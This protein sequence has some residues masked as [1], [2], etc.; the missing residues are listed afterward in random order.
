MKSLQ[1]IFSFTIPFLFFVAQAYSKGTD[2][3]LENGQNLASDDL[4]QQGLHAFRNGFDD[5]ATKF[6]EKLVKEIPFSGNWK[7]KITVLSRL[8]SAYQNLGMKRL[9]LA[10]LQSALVIAN[11][12][13]SEF[14]IQR[15]KGQLGVS[16]TYTPDHKQAE[17]FLSESLNMAKAE[18]NK[19]TITLALMNMGNLRFVEERFDEAVD[20]FEQCIE[21]VDS[22]MNKNLLAKVF[23]NA[24]LSAERNNNWEDSIKFV[25]RGME[26]LKQSED[27]YEK[28]NLLTTA[29]RTYHTLLIHY[30]SLEQNLIT[31]TYNAY[32]SAIKVA[33]DLNNSKFLSYA[34]GYLSEL[35]EFKNLETEALHLARKAAFHAQTVNLPEAL[36]QWQWQV[37]DLLKKSGRL[38]EAIRAYT[39]AVET[40]ETIRHDLSN[41]LGNRSD[42]SSFFR[43]SNALYFE[44]ADLLLL[45]AE[46]IESS[47]KSSQYL[48][49]AREVIELLKSAEIEDYLRD[50]CANIGSSRLKKI[51]TVAEDTA[52][53]YIIPLVDRVELLV[54]ISE[55][56][57]GFKVAITKTILFSEVKRFRNQLE[58]RPIH[59]YLNSAQRIYS[60]LIEPLYDLMVSKGITTLVFISDGPLRTVPMAAL[61]DGKEFLIN[62][63]AIA[64]SPGLTLMAPESIVRKELQVIKSG[65]SESVQG[66]PP[67]NYVTS[68]LESIHELLGGELLL[69]HDFLL[70]DMER[71]VMENQYTIVHIASHGRFHSDPKQ[72]FVLTYDDRLTLNRLEKI[73]RTGQF[74]GKPIELLTLS[75]CETAAGDDRAALGLAGVAMKSGARSVLATLWNINDQASSN[76]IIEFYEQLKIHPSMSKA[77]AL[78]QAQ[79]S[80]LKDLRYDHPC[81]WSPFLI[82]GNWL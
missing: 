1:F 82:V 49:R 63:F 67:L 64:V 76:L 50:E 38:E 34:Y 28:A 20:Y 8:A 52:I 21:L 22:Q 60:W 71:E 43:S 81:Y 17:G 33:E 42:H 55:E 5:Q 30:P 6:W 57:Y 69:D 65:I 35:Y 24:G 47:D 54:T 25:K 29:G 41:S 10:R 40:L 79:L 39:N 80:L 61:H 78:Q 46:K 4:Y 14:D 18:G 36:Y 48:F 58:T 16:Y 32:Q 15:I 9:A 53:V 70:A 74:R 45:Y 44:L 73:L 26:A 72:T 31:E 37:A 59:K 12:Y 13:K 19:E 3:T 56:I 62:Q 51:E 23:I 11:K 2:L 27:S 77:K 68:E 75:A 66:F 7:H